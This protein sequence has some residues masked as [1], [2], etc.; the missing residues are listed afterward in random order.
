MRP[1]YA[2]QIS[3]S[4][5]NLSMA[6]VFISNSHVSPINLSTIMTLTSTGHAFFI[7]L[8]SIITFTSTS[9]KKKLLNLAKTNINKATY[10]D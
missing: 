9:S 4:A 8:Q 10:S 1:V 6:I 3:L 5:I 7:N 2:I